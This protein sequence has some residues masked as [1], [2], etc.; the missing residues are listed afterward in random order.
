MSPFKTNLDAVCSMGSI[1]DSRFVATKQ[2]LKACECPSYVLRCMQH[3]A[4]NIVW[5]K[6]GNRVFRP[7]SRCLFAPESRVIS[8]SRERA[9]R[10]FGE[11]FLDRA[12]VGLILVLQHG[13]IL[14]LFSLKEHSYIRRECNLWGAIGTGTISAQYPICLGRTLKS[15]SGINFVIVPTII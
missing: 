13:L 11:R 12:M 1:P 15:F 7:F 2:Q 10:S 6:V 3:D 14:S 5:G 9:F 8:S 4:H